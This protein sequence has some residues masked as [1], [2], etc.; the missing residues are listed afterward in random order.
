MQCAGAIQ[1]N[2]QINGCA[3]FSECFERNSEESWSA[4][5]M[6]PS[7]VNAPFFFEALL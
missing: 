7:H 2:L 4:D 3:M 5:E 1:V 6:V